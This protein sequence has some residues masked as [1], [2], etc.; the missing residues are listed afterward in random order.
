MRNRHRALALAAG[1]LVAG[2]APAA[3]SATTYCVHL[4]GGC[5][6][7]EI[8]EGASIQQALNDA[9]GHPGMDV[10]QV[11]PG[12]YPGTFTYPVS[13]AVELRGAGA[14]GTVLTGTATTGDIVLNFAST[15][16]TVSDLTVQV[17]GAN[18]QTALL[19][20]VGTVQRVAVD[21]AAGAG[22]NGMV[23]YGPGMVTQS[24]VDVTGAAF[25]TLAGNNPGGVLVTDSALAGTW[26]VIARTVP[27]DLRRTRIAATTAVQATGA[28]V[29]VEDSLLR[30]VA[31]STSGGVVAL[32]SPA[33]PSRVSLDSVTLLGPGSGAGVATQ[34]GATGLATASIGGSIVHGFQTSLRRAS[35]GGD[36]SMI[37]GYNAIDLATYLD[38]GG[39]GALTDAGHNTVADPGFE[40]AT[41][42]HLRADSP[43]VDYIPVADPTGAGTDLDGNP[44]IVGDGLDLGAYEWQ[45]DSDPPATGG[46]SADAPAAVAPEPEPVSPD[47]DAPDAP[48][49]ATA[50]PS[51][52]TRAPALRGACA[53]RGGPG[54]AITWP[55]A[56]RARI[57]WRTSVG[58]HLVAVGQGTRVKAGHGCLGVRVTRRGRALLARRARTPIVIAVTFTPADGGAP[59]RVTR[60]S[61]IGRPATT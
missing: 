15:Q 22:S 36:A 19:M 46:G 48:V 26:G 37:A 17:T 14:G 28:D 42:A 27:V 41:D 18:A 24:Q 57:E 52:A 33:G 10:V 25:Q 3:A 1:L 44:R 55:T 23:F 59:Q 21:G 54:Y 45:G 9:A 11:G 61:A 31:P 49:L 6:P 47:P 32:C 16:A 38:E 7:G 4:T 58:N 20:N 30:I 13:E 34:C 8:D 43:L 51:T 60:R 50:A 35:T 29:H 56:G 53:H 2:A 40:S 39:T 12:S 5:G